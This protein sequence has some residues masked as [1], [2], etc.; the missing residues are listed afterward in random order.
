LLPGNCV[1]ADWGFDIAEDVARTQAKFHIPSFT[2]VLR[3]S[4]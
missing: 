3:P 4:G 1:L 2:R